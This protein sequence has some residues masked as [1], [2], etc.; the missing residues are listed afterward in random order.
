MEE[1]IHGEGV[2][3]RGRHEEVPGKKI[4]VVLGLGKRDWEGRKVN[5]LLMN[6]KSKDTTKARQ[7][8][9]TLGIQKELWLSKNQNGK[10]L[11][12]HDK[13]SFTLDNRKKFYK[14]PSLTDELYAL[15]CGPS[16]NPIAVNYCIVNGV[17][18]VVH[19]RDKRRITQNSGICSPGEKEGEMYYGQLEEILEFLYISFK[20]VSF[21][22]KWFDTSN[23][24]RKVKCF[25][26]R[27]NITQILAS[28]ELF[29]DQQYIIATQ[30]KQVFYLEDMMVAAA[31]NTNNSTI[32]PENKLAHLKQPLIPLPL[33]VASQAARDA[34]D[35][36]NEVA[37]LMLG[38]GWSVRKLLSL[39][40]DKLLRKLYS[41]NKLNRNCLKQSKQSISSYLLK[42]KSYL[43]NMEC[44]GY[45]MPNKLGIPKEAE[46]LAVLAIREGRFHK[47]KKKPQG[48]KVRTKERIC[49]LMLPSPRSHRHLRDNIWQRTL[50]ATAVNRRVLIRLKSMI[51]VMVLIS[52]IILKDLEEAGGVSERRNQ[53]LLDM[54]RSMMNLTTLP[55]SFWGYALESAARILNMVPTKKAHVKRDTP[56]K[57]DSRFIKCIFVYLKEIISYY[58][59]NP[60]KNKI[61]VARNAEFFEN[62]LTLQEASE[63][64]GMLEASGSDV[65]LELIQEYDAQPSKN[66]SK[67]HDE[68]KP[69]EQNPGDIYWTALKTIL[70]YLRNT[71]DMVLVYGEK[72]ESELKVT[73]YADAGFQTDKDDTKSQSG[74]AFVLNGGAV[75][76]KS[77]KQSTTAMSS[78]EEEYI[79]AAEAS[80]EA[81]WMRKFIDGLGDVMPS[82]KRPME[83]LCDNAPN[84]Q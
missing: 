72:P 36:Q 84:R 22:V 39:E 41:K 52:V 4:I 28:S 54:V 13:Y 70:K 7:D 17:R 34:Y 27:N 74:Y 37:C 66:T 35:M 71:K 32:R 33:P 62:N 57:L 5:T 25:A 73:C 11:K 3:L 24:G 64:H 12:P 6:D 49:L 1:G 53:S 47:D 67:R 76:W 18:F 16:L 60:L 30:V 61:F 59:Y 45:A 82:N 26:I 31:Q 50:S 81:V 48:A 78:I 9:K 51:R 80:M 29:N 79:V 55:N 56:D 77:D 69:N 38:R 10:C 46:T 63:S 40:D 83:M 43:D 14:D 65:G 58:F 21:R 20:V 15:A 8:L 2:V 75:D 68:I 42:M 44:L 19:S 23:E